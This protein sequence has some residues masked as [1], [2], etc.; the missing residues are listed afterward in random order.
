MNPLARILSEC[1][2]REQQRLCAAGI[3]GPG[4]D[5][6]DLG[7]GGRIAWRPSA[8]IPR[9]KASNRHRPQ[10][11]LKG[12]TCPKPYAAGATCWCPLGEHIDA[13]LEAG[14]FTEASI[15]GLAG[16]NYSDALTPK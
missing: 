1:Q 11:Q 6:L 10:G 2:G 3:A 15:L 12:W 9:C 16:A 8:R 4:H 13:L 5:R 7:V 14:Q